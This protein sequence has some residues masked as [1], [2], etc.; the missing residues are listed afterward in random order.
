ME[1]DIAAQGDPNIYEVYK[2]MLEQVR[3]IQ[4]SM[5]ELD[6]ESKKRENNI[7][8]LEKCRIKYQEVTKNKQKKP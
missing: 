1:N 4:T 7:E 3:A 8:Q 5:D 2:L 6:R